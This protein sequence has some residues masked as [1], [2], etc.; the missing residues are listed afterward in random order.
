MGIKLGGIMKAP[1]KD[2]S[3]RIAPVD[4]PIAIIGGIGGDMS[5]FISYLQQTSQILYQA[6]GT[7][8]DK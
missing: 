1:T 4:K 7:N 6:S 2:N 5:A 8:K 3:D